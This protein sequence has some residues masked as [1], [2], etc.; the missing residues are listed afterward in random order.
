MSKEKEQEVKAEDL[1][2]E[3]PSS[4][5]TNE[6]EDD[7]SDMPLPETADYKEPNQADDDRVL[8]PTPKFYKLFNECLGKMPYASVL[9]NSNNDQIKL[10]DL[11]KFVE[12]KADGLTVKE[13]NTII[14]FVA[15][16]P[17]EFVRPFMEIV[18]TAERQK[19]LWILK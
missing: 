3:L 17:L 1:N 4:I 10:V 12:V 18:E 19:E 7:D 11:I 6:F 15:G 5:L 8:L 2:L 9:K 13:M 16:C 14:S